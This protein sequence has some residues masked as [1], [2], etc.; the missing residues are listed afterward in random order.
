MQTKVSIIVPVY[1][2]SKYIKRCI[3]SILVQTF[4]N[5]ELILVDDGSQDDSKFICESYCEKDLRIKVLS[6]DNFGPSSARNLGIDNALG[7][8]ITFVDSDD[9]IT[10]DAIEKLIS[11]FL[12][13]HNIE[14]S[15]GGY[16]EISVLQPNKLIV[17]HDFENFEKKIIT[18]N[19]FLKNIFCGVTG[20]LWGKMFLLNKIKKHHI[21]LNPEVKLAE[22][23]LFVFEYVSLIEKIYLVKDSLYYYNRLNV[24]GLTTNYKISNLK[25]LEI[26][27]SKL[28]EL[29]KKNSVNNLEE[30]LRT[31]YILIFIK[32]VKANALSNISKKEKIKN[33]HFLKKHELKLSRATISYNKQELINIFL[34]DKSFYNLLFLFNRMLV[35]KSKIQSFL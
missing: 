3:D 29:G 25:D 26:T 15:C 1:N 19:E 34:F 30:I 5:W 11:P 14:L 32:I 21:R 8:F 13:D 24:E 27:N 22:D 12:I 9:Y 33:F 10:I 20:V 2:A 31:R 28:R 35:F 6:Q 16:F 17:L 7:E 4:V 18:K 23:V